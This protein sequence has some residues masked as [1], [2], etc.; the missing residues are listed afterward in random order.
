MLGLF[1]SHNLPAFVDDT[2]GLVWAFMGLGSCESESFELHRNEHH[3][4]LLTDHY[5]L[6]A[7]IL[8]IDGPEDRKSSPKAEL[9]TDAPKEYQNLISKGSSSCSSNPNL[10]ALE[11]LTTSS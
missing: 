6:V 3:N 5:P 11:S 1:D 2:P 9:P 7:K 10:Q 4:L 8:L